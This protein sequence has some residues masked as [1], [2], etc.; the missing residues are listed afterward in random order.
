[1]KLFLA[2]LLNL[3][4]IEVTDYHNFD[5]EIIVEVDMKNVEAICPNCGNISHSLHQN[6]WHLIRDLPISNKD[7]LLR[8]NRRQFK[9]NFCQ[10]P[11]SEHLH[12]VE[13]RKKFTSRYAEFIVKQLINSNVA[14]VAVNNKLSEWEVEKMIDYVAKK[15]LPIDLSGLKRLGIDEI[16]LV[17]G[18]GKFIV[19]LVDLD[20]G[21]LIGL[22][23]DKKKIAIEKVLLSW[24]ERVLNQIE[25]V[26]MDMAKIYKSVVNNLCE[27]AVITVDRFHVTKILHNEL[28]QARI[29]QKQTAE[30]LKINSREKLLKSMKGCKYVLLK[31]EENLNDKQAKKLEIIKLASPYLEIMHELK[32]EFTEIFDNSNDWEEGTFK[33]I[34]WLKK[35]RPF[36]KKTVRIIINWFQEVVGYFERRTNQGM[37]EG[38]NNRLKVIKRNGFG[39]KQFDNFEKRSLLF[40]HF[41]NTLA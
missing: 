41:P 12:F 18:Q 21:K 38:I 26:S 8:V 10:K 22:V 3:E 29:S 16:S 6:H 33:L 20:T 36:F 39:F 1:M 7:V 24:G 30:E 13:K 28:N 34:D 14:S 17:K 32:E 19:V 4:G 15:V 9:C 37:V 5:H 27:N 25:E 23:K 40:F 31:R 11:F 35:A 2:E